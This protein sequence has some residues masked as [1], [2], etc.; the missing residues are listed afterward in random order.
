MDITLSSDPKGP[1]LPGGIG[2]EGVIRCSP[3]RGADRLDG[4]ELGIADRAVVPRAI[5]ELTSTFFDD[6][7]HFPSGSIAFDDALVMR[8]TPH[9]RR[10]LAARSAEGATERLR[11]P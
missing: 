3:R 4:V 7:V 11:Q 5:D 10:R 2:L 1:A 9:V 6:P 8:D